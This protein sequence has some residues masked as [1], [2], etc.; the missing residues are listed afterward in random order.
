M[1]EAFVHRGCEL[2][3]EL[4]Y[5][6]DRDVWVRLETDGDATL[7][8]MDTAQT[9]C[10]KLVHVRFK[11]VGRSLRRQQ[12]AATIESAKWVGPFP[13]PLSGEIV[14]TNE[15]TFAR[16]I[17]AANKDPYGR[18]WLV[19]VRPSDLDAE[20]AGLA[21]GETARQHFR[22]RIEELGISCMRCAEEGTA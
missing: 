19:R 4:L 12:S 21:E 20:R 13:T 7:G 17:L 2:P 10:G 14:A 1:T 15:E 18:G 6:I 9:Q 8:M 22:A 16:D 3:A 5:A 11:P